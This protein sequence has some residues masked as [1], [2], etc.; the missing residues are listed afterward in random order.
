MVCG[1]SAPVTIGRLVSQCAEAM[2]I[3]L[4]LPRRLPSAA[5]ARPAGPASRACIGEPCEIKTLG[6]GTMA[7]AARAGSLGIRPSA[8]IA[9]LTFG[10][11]ATRLWYFCRFG[12][13]ERSIC[14]GLVQF[15]STKRYA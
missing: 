14:V 2:R 6:R 3:A 13:F 7:Y 8:C 11:A 12:H 1:W 5:H 15:V 4:G 9:S 10:R